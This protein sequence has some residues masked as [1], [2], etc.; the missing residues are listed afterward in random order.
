MNS[1][2]KKATKVRRRLSA[3]DREQQ[4]VEEAIHFF[5]EGGFG[6]QTRELA[7]RLNI[8]QPLLYRYFPTKQD[9]IERVFNEVY[10]NR[11]NPSWATLLRDRTRSLHDRLGDFYRHY[12]E[13]TYRYEWI[14]LYMFSGLRGEILNRRYIRIVE[15][16][17]LMPIC[18]EIRDYCGWPSVDEKPITEL[19]LEQVWVMHGGL[20]YYA[21]RKHIYHSE[22]SDDFPAVVSQVVTTVL[23]G[24]QSRMSKG[25]P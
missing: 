19:E 2:R 8:T 7:Q 12:S 20:F 6:G 3:N 23:E 25:K 21:V 9:L 22:V 13:A 18:E 17:L 24:L 15:D 11:I 4:I 5:A 10:I 1:K 16:T 14:R